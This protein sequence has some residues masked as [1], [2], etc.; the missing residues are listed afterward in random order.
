[1]T[2]AFFYIPKYPFPARYP[3]SKLINPPPI[4]I[5]IKKLDPSFV[6]L[7]KPAIASVNMHGHKVEQNNPTLINANTL[8]IPSVAIPIIKAVMPNKENK[9][10]CLAGFP[11]LKRSPIIKTII[12]NA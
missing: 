2:T 7:P 9:S 8:V 3:W 11:L 4:I 6:C 1:M 5:M 10:N 12:T